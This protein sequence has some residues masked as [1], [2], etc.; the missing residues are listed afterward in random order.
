M[1]P[2]MNPRQMRQMMKRMGVAQQEIEATQVIIKTSEGN[3]IFN[4]PQVSKVNMMGQETYQIVGAAEQQ[5]AEP[6]DTAPEISE[7]DVKTV[8]EQ[9][10]VSEAQA[11]EAIEKSN[12]DLAE[13]ILSLDPE[14]NQ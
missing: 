3:L 2:G 12:G 7:E 14:Q 6:E 8:M 1:I 13:A 9:A 5:E 11:K 10:N 4:N